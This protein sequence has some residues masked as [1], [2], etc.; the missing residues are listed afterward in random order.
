MCVRRQLATASIDANRPV[1]GAKEGEGFIGIHR[2]N[3][4]LLFLDVFATGDMSNGP[5]LFSEYKQRAG[6]T[7]LEASIM[8]LLIYRSSSRDLRRS[9]FYMIHTIM[10]LLS[11]RRT[12]FLSLSYFSPS[13]PFSLSV[14]HSLPLRCLFLFVPFSLFGQLLCIVREPSARS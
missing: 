7:E 10:R 12:S 2:R 4:P 13:H 3:V 1:C 5:S 6:Y 8:S 11:F 9:S 14:F